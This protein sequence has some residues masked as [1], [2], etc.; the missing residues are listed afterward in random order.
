MPT[1]QQFY[2]QLSSENPKENAYLETLANLA[3]ESLS[4]FLELAGGLDWYY[5]TSIPN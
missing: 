2:D 1:M 4:K 3:R 5:W